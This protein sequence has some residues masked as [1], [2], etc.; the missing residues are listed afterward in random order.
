MDLKKELENNL[1]ELQDTYAKGIQEQQETQQRLNAV[2]EELVLLKG[3]ARSIQKL[4]NKLTKE[5]AK[6]GKKEDPENLTEEAKERIEKENQVKNDRE[7]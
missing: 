7:N 4:I 2:T 5:T 3:E 1:K 6:K